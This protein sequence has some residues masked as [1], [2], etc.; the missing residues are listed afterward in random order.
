MIIARQKKKENIIE[1]LL[2]MF[3]VEDMI[4]ACELDMKKLER[5][6]LPGYQADNK[7]MPEISEWYANHI[8]MMKEE[9][10]DRKGHLVYI[11]N[12]IAELEELHI[13]LLKKAGNREY[14][15]HYQEAL[16]GIRDLKVRLK[17]ETETD[18]SACLNG[19]YGYLLLRI[20]KKEISKETDEAIK[21]ISAMLA[22]LAGQH[23]K[24]ENGEIEL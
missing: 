8:Q 6:V 7:L 3:Q 2:Y 23:K 12:H 24:I 10:K 18:I 15:K 14:L 17:K 11:E 9:H 22:Y 13:Y 16:P 4:R 1:Y 19:L 5:D 21:K 20:Q